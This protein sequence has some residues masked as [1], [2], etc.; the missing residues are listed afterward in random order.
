MACIA[1]FGFLTFV[2]VFTY[3]YFAKDLTTL[4][5]VM[6]KNDTGVVLYDRNGKVFY[7]FYEAHYKSLVPLE[8]IPQSMQQAVIAGEDSGFYHHPGF[9]IKG[10]L[11][12]LVADVRKRDTAYGGSTITQQLV[13]NTLLNTRKNL[14]RK[15]QEIILAQEIDRRYTKNQILYAYLNSVYFGEGAFGVE[16]AAKTYFGVPASKLSL[17]QSS[18]LAGLLTAPSKYSPLSG[19]R[20]AA[21]VR[22]SYVLGKMVEEKYITAEQKAAAEQEE[23]HYNVQGRDDQYKAPHF[24]LMVRDELIKKY[25]EETVARSGFQVFT[26]LDVDWQTYAEKVVA[27]QVKRLAPN[28]V[29]NGAA[30]VMDP[31]TGEIRVLVGS[32]NWYEDKNNLTTA[33]R[34]PGSSFKPIVYAKAM[35][36]RLITPAT[37][38]NDSPRTFGKNYSPRNYD[39]KFR[40]PVT[41]R[42]ALSNSLNVPAVDV[43]Q[44][45]GLSGAV[46]MAKD[47]G[48]TTIEDD[49]S[50]FGLAI[51]LGGA[52]VPLIQMTGAYATF[53]NEGKYNTPTIIHL[54]RNKYG[55][56]L[57]EHKPEPKEV[58]DPGVAFL[59]S[60][61]LSDTK[62]R[63]EIFGNVLDTVR[64]AAVKTGTTESYR[65]SLTMGYTPSLA[66]GVWVG[67]DDNTPMDTIAGSVGAAPIF[68]SLIEG[69]LKGTPVEQFRPPSGVVTTQNCNYIA[70][71]SA[72]M[73]YFLE[74]TQSRR[75]SAT[76]FPT[77]NITGAP[78][79]MPTIPLTT[80]APTQ[81]VSPTTQPTSPPT[82]QPSPTTTSSN[83]VI[84][85]GKK[86]K[87]N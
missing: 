51:V 23:L 7:K 60:S 14:L 75:C 72:S 19:D 58:L 2:P 82:V 9:S 15:Y 83:G 45:V 21:K 32:R 53:A 6:N 1:F 57:Y 46:D 40:G 37:L 35:E 69:L 78:S 18:M 81:P 28:R 16:E 71:M 50:R 67:N 17:A 61:I 73:E 20:A 43:M 30:V 74:G 13:K 65:D 70:T 52:E 44:R 12:A 31:K 76:P 79:A 29:S 68:K 38:I 56:T 8:S 25:G 48:I 24:A 84:R 66:V 11:G 85:I 54:I 49:P 62:A 47:L 80:P 4:E 64:P 3:A 41:V 26:T 63:K 33:L 10:M 34:Q 55:E 77:Q 86:V 36:Q 87:F 27:D 22:Q 39:G 59:I 5:G 42:R